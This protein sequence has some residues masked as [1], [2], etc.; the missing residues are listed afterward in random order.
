MGGAGLMGS[1]SGGFGT[2][3]VGGHSG[4]GLGT[5]SSGDSN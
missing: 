4:F 5:G 3:S 2:G 1:V